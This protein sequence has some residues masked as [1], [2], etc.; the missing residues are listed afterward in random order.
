ML[1]KMNCENGG[2]AIN[3]EYIS[4]D[5]DGSTT[6]SFNNLIVGKHYLLYL[7]Q[8]ASVAMAYDRCDIVSATNCEYTLIGRR[9]N[10]TSG[11]STLVG[12]Y[13]DIVPSNESISV[14][15]NGTVNYDLMLI[16]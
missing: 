2:G 16:N 5:Y 4:G 1:V 6:K 3:P 8:D 10:M 11:T 13:H 15:A 7:Y 9:N 14:T 12:S